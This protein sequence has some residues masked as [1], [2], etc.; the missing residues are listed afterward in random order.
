[1]SWGSRGEAVGWPWGAVGIRA[2]PWGRCVG[3]GGR[4]GPWGTVSFLGGPWKVVGKPWGS[5]GQAVGAHGLSGGQWRRVGNPW[6]SRERPW[7][8]LG[9]RADALGRPWE[10]VVIRERPMEP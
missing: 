8:L 3:V 1:M 5:C 10:S 9:S 7:S 4:A 2:G 6:G